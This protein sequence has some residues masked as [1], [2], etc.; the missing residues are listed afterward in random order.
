MK[1]TSAARFYSDLA[2]SHDGHIAS[3]EAAPLAPRIA[4]L[5]A[6]RSCVLDFGRP[7][8]FAR[9]EGITNPQLM[10]RLDSSFHCDKL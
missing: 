8:A 7:E 6:Q 4:A 10:R 1:A 2:S 5:L 9:P 3:R